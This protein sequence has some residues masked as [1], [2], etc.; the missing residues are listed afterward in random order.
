MFLA[1]SG[2][3]IVASG[4]ATLNSHCSLR[5]TSVYASTEVMLGQKMTSSVLTIGMF[6]RCIATLSA[7]SMVHC[8]VHCLTQIRSILV[9][10][11]ALVLAECC[12]S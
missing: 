10:V 5:S 12:L 2:V 8:Y 4:E 11:A 1:V 9:H 7:E 6:V 3:D